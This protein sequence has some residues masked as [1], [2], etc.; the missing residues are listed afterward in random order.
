[1]RI[2][3]EES[4]FASVLRLF[5][6]KLLSVFETGRDR[7]IVTTTA[8]IG[9]RG[10]GCFLNVQPNSTYYCNCYGKTEVRAANLIEQFEGDS[11]QCTST[12]LRWKKSNGYGSHE[13]C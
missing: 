13:S 1:M 10:T 5:T 6:G 12:G 11:S 4:S 7:E 8:T 3:S 9:I 2:E